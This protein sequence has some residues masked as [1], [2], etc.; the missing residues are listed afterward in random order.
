MDPLP[1]MFRG[2]APGCHATLPHAAERTVKHE[3]NPSS[4]GTYSNR[5]FPFVRFL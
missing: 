1:K 3:T 5:P 4:L 2:A